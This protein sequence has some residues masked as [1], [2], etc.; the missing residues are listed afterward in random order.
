PLP[1]FAATIFHMG[2]D[3]TDL[4]QFGDTI[5]GNYFNR[6]VFKGP[7]SLQAEAARAAL[8]PV[9]ERFGMSWNLRDQNHRSK[10]LLLV[11]RFDHCL[12][13]LL[14]RWRSGELRM[15][16]VGI[17]SNYPRETYSNLMLGDL[18]FWYL[19]ITKETKA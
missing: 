9:M 2:G 15:D 14:Y 7:S 19:P 8:A 1:I 18:P 5:T 11:S 17:V 12:V 16:V 13:D 4:Q 6:I 3:I 10:V